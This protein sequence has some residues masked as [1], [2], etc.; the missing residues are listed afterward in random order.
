V[1]QL[2][3]FLPFPQHGIPSINLARSHFS[4][5]R[6]LND[7]NSPG[8][9][10]ENININL[11]ALGDSGQETIRLQI[12]FNISVIGGQI[13]V[14]DIPVKLSG[15]TRLSCQAWLL[16]HSNGSRPGLAVTAVTRVLVRQWPL[17]SDPKVELLVF[18]EEVIE[19]DGKKVQQTDMYEV[20]I[21]MNQNFQKLRR[22]TYSYP[23]LESMLFSIPRERDVVVTDPNSPKK[24]EDQGIVHTTSHYPLKQAETTQ[25]ETAAPGKLPETPLRMDP[26]TWYE[27]DTTAEEETLPDK[28]LPETP[29]RSESMSSYNAVCRWVEQLRDRLKRFWS[30]SLPVFFLV[31]WVVVVG[32][33]GSAVIIKILDVIFP[34]CDSKGILL[35]N[36]VTLL[37]E[38]DKQCLLENMEEETQTEK[39]P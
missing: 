17:E 25:E 39:Q 35:L 15:V 1:L 31:M 13:F 33:T 20:N 23:L 37:P 29:L 24:G 18:N 21:L 8:W 38:E 16:E 7:L 30:E 2:Y 4:Q 5:Q 3:P 26:S 34:T 22:T 19:V 36:P 9:M 10:E 6:D 28:L 11:T 12:K 27:E 14:N 32:V